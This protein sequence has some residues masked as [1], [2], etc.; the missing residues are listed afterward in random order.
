[1]EI[2]NGEMNYQ[3]NSQVRWGCFALPSLAVRVFYCKLIPCSQSLLQASRIL[4]KPCFS[5]S[6][7][8]VFSLNPTLNLS[9]DR[10][11]FGGT[12]CEV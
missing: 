5:A 3:V 10:A 11:C 2:H 1:M 12:N 4:H 6:I 7:S 8:D 9:I